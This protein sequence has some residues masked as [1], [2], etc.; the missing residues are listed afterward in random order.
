MEDTLW[1][2]VQS[3]CI[4]VGDDNLSLEPDTY[5]RIASYYYLEHKTMRLFGSA[6][7]EDMDIP[8]LLKVC[9]VLRPGPGT[10]VTAA[11]C[12]GIRALS[13]SVCVS[14]QHSLTPCFSSL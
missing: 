8:S 12:W 7:K 10:N 5:G 14:P 1:E 2:L 13:A 9:V 4:T 11:Q 6:I 3:G